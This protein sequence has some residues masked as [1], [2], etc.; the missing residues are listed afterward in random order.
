MKKK[1]TFCVEGI[2]DWKPYLD[3]VKKTG[4]CLI[5]IGFPLPPFSPRYVDNTVMPLNTSPKGPIKGSQAGCASHTK[6][7]VRAQGLRARLAP[8]LIRKAYTHHM[9][10]FCKC[11]SDGVLP[12]SQHQK[13]I[14]PLNSTFPHLFFLSD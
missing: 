8:L 9:L 6:R 11:Q 4:V 1:G 5:T 3:A 14:K 13:Q 10:L 12:S 2:Y 7:R